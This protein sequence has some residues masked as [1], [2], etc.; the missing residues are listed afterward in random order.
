MRSC[1]PHHI[2]S[3]E[4]TAPR[5]PFQKHTAPGQAASA[6]IG[7]SSIRTSRQA[8]SH[9]IDRRKQACCPGFARRPKLPQAVWASV[10]NR[11]LQSE[12]QRLLWRAAASVLQ[13]RSSASRI[14]R[15]VDLRL[16][17]VDSGRSNVVPRRACFS[18][19]SWAVARPNGQMANFPGGFGAPR[20]K[21]D[22]RVPSHCRACRPR[23]HAASAS[24]LG[25]WHPRGEAARLPA[26]S[27]IRPRA[28]CAP[29]PAAAS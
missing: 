19:R 13:H 25:C 27:S 12:P 9:A 1:S 22:R 4:I 18:R 20:R 2:P 23:W 10:C 14:V 28:C 5:H 21:Q 11:E 24:R 26:R 29:S 16:T 6:A 8:S 7:G 15:W 17:W 3:N